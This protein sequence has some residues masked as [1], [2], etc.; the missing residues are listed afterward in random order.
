[1]N[2]ESGGVLFAAILLIILLVIPTGYEDA[3]SYQGGDRVRARVLSTDERFVKDSGLVRTG[4]QRCTVEI[5]GGLFKGETVEATNRLSGSLAQDKLFAAGDVAYV[6]VSHSGGEIIAVTMT[7][8]FRL[9]KEILLMILFLLFLVLFAGKTGVRAI[10]SFVNTILIM[11]KVLVPCLLNGWNP[12]WLTLGLV[13]LM[14]M[15]LLS[16]IF[17]FDRRCLAAFLGAVLGIGVTAILGIVFTDT[18]KIH[19]AVLESSESLLYAGYQHLDLTGIFMASIFLGASGSVVDLAVDISSS[20]YEV[21]QKKPDI[22]AKEAVRSGLTVGRAAC[23]SNIT[24]LLFAYSGSFITLLMVFMA[25]GTPMEMMLN[26][27]YV[28]SEIVHTIVGSFGLITV[29]PLTAVTSGCLLVKRK[30]DIAIAK[31]S[32]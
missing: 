5:L 9:D 23:A 24:T 4:E 29:A 15:I 22:T 10:L 17:G 25:Q 2:K 6:V 31:D 1:M 18:M 21:V 28:A 32:Q 26:Y 12:V 16:L 20:V 13:V 30:Q 7:D 8:H 11:W 3:A 19:G 27:K 14:V